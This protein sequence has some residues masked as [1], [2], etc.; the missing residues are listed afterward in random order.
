MLRVVLTIVLLVVPLASR[1]ADLARV[2]FSDGRYYLYAAPSGAPA[3]GLVVALHGGGGSP[4]Q[5]ARTS[6]LADAAL[7]AGFAVVF[8][9][10][11]TARGG[12]FHVWNAL[13]CCASAVKR[14]AD[15]VAF[16][17]RVISDAERR[18]GARGGAYLT[19]MS[20]GAMMA[21]TYAALRP[22]RVAALATVAGVM[23]ISRVPVRGAVPFLH[24]HGTADGSVPYGGGSGGGFVTDVIFPSVEN[25][26][27]AFLRPHG[28]TT[29]RQDAID[30]RRDGTRV[31]RTEWVRGGRAAVVL[32]T[33]EDGGHVWPGSVRAR[34]LGATREIDAT[35]EVVRFFSAWR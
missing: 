5:F 30:R 6:G 12:P 27:L 10:G 25:V 14:G 23:D 34:G 19:G 28:A 26:T 8:P 22:G 4:E 29:R 17:D 2:A 16:L 24:I 18:T 21:Q 1:A 31:L 7:R 20:N 13:Y 32:L 33:V 35:T 11:T 9:A 15:D 3:S